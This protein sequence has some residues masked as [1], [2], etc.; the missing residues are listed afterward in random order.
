MARVSL[1]N[2][3]NVKSLPK[4]YHAVDAPYA[5]GGNRG[6]YIAALP[7]PYP[8]NRPQRIVSELASMCKIK[9]GMSKR[10]LMTAM[11]DCVTKENYEKAAKEVK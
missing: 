9:S 4:R 2:F 8:K 3:S 6:F 7:R 10:E 1:T 5:T 11:K